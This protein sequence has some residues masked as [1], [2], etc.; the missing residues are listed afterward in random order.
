ML[1]VNKDNYEE[2]L[3]NIGINYSW[4]QRDFA[5][6]VSGFFKSSLRKIMIISGLSGTGK[7]VGILQSILNSTGDFSDA[8]Y[9]TVT[10][11]NEDCAGEL[12]TYLNNNDYKIIAIDEITSIKNFLDDSFIGYLYSLTEKGKR[13]IITGAESF[14]LEG[15]KITG[16]SGRNYSLHTNFSSLDEY[17]RIS[18]V[19][20]NRDNC[21]NYLRK[22]GFFKS[23]SMDSDSSLVGYVDNFIVS[24]LLN[25]IA[26][27]DIKIM[28]PENIRAVVYT[29]FYEC[30]KS[31]LSD[32]G[33]F[34]AVKAKLHAEIP[35]RLKKHGIDY[36]LDTISQKDLLSICDLFEKA[37][38]LITVDNFIPDIN[39]KENASKADK[40]DK[41]FF[42]GKKAYITIPSLAYSFMRLIY[43][44]DMAESSG[45]LTLLYENACV[46]DISYHKQEQDS[47]YFLKSDFNKSDVNDS[48]EGRT[49]FM[50][51]RN[52]LCSKRNIYLFEAVSDSDYYDL[53]CE[54]PL[55]N[56]RVNET[57][58]NQCPD[59]DIFRYLVHP[60]DNPG[61]KYS[62]KEN[63]YEVL[64]VNPGRLFHEYY[65]YDKNKTEI[66]R[67]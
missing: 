4:K 19:S 63:G 32:K 1:I 53:N 25:Y 49:V 9:I 17:C 58:L 59:A 41:S 3:E 18:S 34:K 22:G 39:P 37:G 31:M 65:E 42:K 45:C 6:K 30:I 14:V 10:A 21:L 28:E 52:N 43:G 36:D 24:N 15:L 40:A 16:L 61:I 33:Y 23:Y 38:I 29:L 8:V 35:D 57:I 64:S 55:V 5:D 62:E 13:V 47:I 11:K 20:M 51:C 27:C 46:C 56:D 2:Y 44:Q 67:L 50:V 12:I 60:M 26:S 66:E 7:S 48:F 54:I